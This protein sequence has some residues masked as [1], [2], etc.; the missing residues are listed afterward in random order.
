MA[1]KLRPVEP[2]VDKLGSCCFVRYV[3][4]T[5]QTRL[6]QMIIFHLI[7][8]VPHMAFSKIGL[9][10]NRK[11]TLCDIQYIKSHS[12]SCFL[13]FKLFTVMFSLAVSQLFLD[14]EDILLS[15][16]STVQFESNSIILNNILYFPTRTGSLIN[17]Q[18]SQRKWI[19]I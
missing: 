8:I 6:N 17:F 3:F 10:N 9:F 13:R 14:A 15:H 4:K 11:I 2:R 5:Q 18:K 16:V 19:R 7:N 12:K 1:V